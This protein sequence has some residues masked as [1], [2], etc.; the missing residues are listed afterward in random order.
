M[1]ISEMFRSSC[2]NWRQWPQGAAETAKCWSRGSALRMRLVMRNCSAW[3][4]WWSGRPG[5]STLPPKKIRPED[6]SPTAPTWKFEIGGLARVWADLTSV[7]RSWRTVS[8]DFWAID[9]ASAASI[10]NLGRS[11]FWV[12]GLTR[13]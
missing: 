8:P 4:D 11:I 3:M 7:G 1:L 2:K 13:A 5:N 10:T 6:P 9:S 12:S